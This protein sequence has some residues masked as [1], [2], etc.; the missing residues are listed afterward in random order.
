[1][2][3]S[4][5]LP[6]T[7][8]LFHC[9]RILLILALALCTAAPLRAA[10]VTERFGEHATADVT[11]V[12]SD[13]TVDPNSPGNVDPLGETLYYR[14][15]RSMIMRFDL[16]AI[17]SGTRIRRAVVRFFY[18]REDG[19]FTL[20][21]YEGGKD[22]TIMPLRILFDPQ[23]S[24]GWVPGEASFLNKRA[25][26]PWNVGGNFEGALGVEIGSVYFR[27]WYARGQDWHDARITEAVQYWV[28]N[29]ERN[30]G[31]GIG[32]A[33]MFNKRICS[34]R[35]SDAMRRPY[36][37]V[38]YE[39]D[40]AQAPPQS[41]EVEAV[42]TDGQ[43]FVTWNEATT[44][45]DETS[46]RIYRHDEPIT[47]GNLDE[48]E[49]LDE[50]YQGS[51][52]ISDAAKIG[53][54]D[55]SPIGV[56]LEPRAGLFVY[57]VENAQTS[58]YAVTTVVE[59]NEN[60]II[61]AGNT[62][63]AGVS[64]AIGLPRPFYFNH[65]G[66]DRYYI[67]LVMFLGSFNPEN[68]ADEFGFD[69]RRSA[70]FFFSVAE[71]F[72][73]DRDLRYP[74]NLFLHAS[75]KSYFGSGEG[76]D[77]TRVVDGE[78]FGGFALGINDQPRVV[79]RNAAGDLLDLGP[80][81]ETT[82][83]GYTYYAGFNSNYTPGHIKQGFRKSL[84]ISQPFSQ[85]RNVL[86]TEKSIM[87]VMDWLQER[88]P[89]SQNIDSD[90]V[91]ANGYSMG[92]AGVL[93]LALHYPNRIAVADAVVGRTAIV[94]Q[95][96]Y[97]YHAPVH[98]GTTEMGVPTPEGD[99]LFAKMRL[100]QYIKT[101]PWVEFPPIR[102]TN[103]RNDFV[104][105]W[106]PAP[107]FWKA[108]LSERM[109]IISLW[110]TSEHNGNWA[111]AQPDYV[112]PRDMVAEMH[113]D[114]FNLFRYSLRESYPAFGD[115]SLDDDP[116]NGPR[117][118]GD[119]T[120]GI[121]RYP[122]WER[123][124]L[125]DELNRYEVTVFMLDSAPEETATVTVIPRRIQFLLHEPG[126]VYD[127]RNE[128]LDGGGTLQS[129]VV[130][131][132]GYH[133]VVVEGFE[134]G[135]QATRLVLE[136][137]TGADQTPPSAP[138]VLTA[139]Q[140]T[141][142][143]IVLNWSAANDDT[144]VAGYVVYN[145]EGEAVRRVEGTGATIANLLN[146]VSYTFHVRAYDAAGNLSVPSAPASAQ[147]HA[148]GVN[149]PPFIDMA[150][151]I[152]V[153]RGRKLELPI[154]AGDP[155]SYLPRVSV[156]G[157]PTGASYDA[158]TRIVTWLPKFDQAGDHTIS[159]TVE[160]EI[161][162]TTKNVRL[163]VSQE[164]DPARLGKVETYGAFISGGVQIEV[165]GSDGNEWARLYVARAEEAGPMREAHPFVRY[166]LNHMATSLF[167]LEAGTAYRVRVVMTDPDGGVTTTETLLTTRPEWT[168][169]APVREV[170]IND[171]EELRAAI[172][173]V[174]PGDHLVLAPGS[175][176]GDFELRDKPGQADR[177]IVLR[178]RDLNHK[179]VLVGTVGNTRSPYVTYCGLEVIEGGIAARGAN[180]LEIV[181]CVISD[182]GGNYESALIHISH[183][184]EVPG[185]DKAGHN[186]I[187]NNLLT[188]E[189]STGPS[190]RTYF[191]IRRH[192]GVRGFDIIRGNIIRGVDDGISPGG[193]EGQSP[194]LGP[195]AT[196]VLKSWPNQN[197]DIYDNVIYDMADDCIETDG[198]MVNCRI[199]NNIL[200]ASI[201]AVSTA[202]TW[203]GP[204]FIVRNRMHGF[205]ENS[206][207]LNTGVAGETRNVFMYH[208]T[209]KQH[210][211]S[212]YC[213]YRGLP[214]RNRNIIWR[215]NIIEST[216]RII[217]TDISSDT[218][219]DNHHTNHSFDHDLLWTP[220][221]PGGET[222]LFKWGY[223]T[224]GDNE[225]Y[226]SL[227][228]FQAATANP[229][230]TFQCADQR[231]IPQEPNGI[232]G[233]PLLAEDVPANYGA[234][235]LLL[236]LVPGTGSPAIDA[237]VAIP[238][239][240]DWFEGAG[241]DI[242]AIEVGRDSGAAPRLVAD[243]PTNLFVSLLDSGNP[244]TVTIEG[245]WE[246]YSATDR[247]GGSDYFLN[248]SEAGAGGSITFHP[249]IEQEGGYDVY[250]YYVHHPN[251][252]TRVPVTIEHARGVD[253][254]TINQREPGGRFR[255]I[256]QYWFAPGR[257]AA[258][259]FST[260][261]VD[262]GYVIVD[263]V[264]LI[265][266]VDPRKEAVEG[267]AY[268]SQSAMVTPPVQ[269]DY[270]DT[271]SA[272]VGA[273]ISVWGVSFGEERNGGSVLIGDVAA[274]EY[275]RWS[276]ERIDFR[277]PEGAASGPLWVYASRGH[278][279][280]L[281]FAVRPGDLHLVD[282]GH[283][284][285]SDSG[286][287][288]MEQPWAT[289]A[290]AAAAAEAGDTIYIAQGIYNETLEP[291]GTGTEGLPIVFKGLPGALPLL[292][293]GGLPDTPDGIR[294][295][296]SGL[297]QL[298]GHMVFTDLLLRNFDQSVHIGLG[299][300][301]IGL[302]GLDVGYG[303]GGL[304][305][306]GSSD[307]FVAHCR[308]HNNQDFG[309]VFNNFASDIEIRDSA[310]HDNAALEGGGFEADDTVS[311][312]TLHRCVAYDNPG[313]GYDLRVDALVVNESVGF[314]N[315]IGLRLWRNAR[316]QNSQFNDNA[317]CGIVCERVGADQ[318]MQQ[319][320]NC[321]VAGGHAVAGIDV[322]ELVD[323]RVINTIAV[324]SDGPAM[325]FEGLPAGDALENLI[326]HSTGEETL[327]L[328]AAQA[329]P[330]NLN[331]LDIEAGLLTDLIGVSA[332]MRVETNPTSLFLDMERGDLRLAE[333]SAARGF[334]L[335]DKAPGHDLVRNVRHDYGASV[336]AGAFEFP[337]GPASAGAAWAQYR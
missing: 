98:W 162:Q 286:P 237:A 305:M 32:T 166:D 279:Q 56:Y 134:I 3:S 229:D 24:G 182:A 131:A 144:G 123:E 106:R 71:P 133:R 218:P 129:G 59:G 278:T 327:L 147:T 186:L 208:N 72:H 117:E 336:D 35:S 258:I 64:E 92:S 265:L 43:T 312:V 178:S 13:Q 125:V 99:D 85:G 167:D 188:D 77:N 185:A 281:G 82:D 91:M 255:A 103:N 179:A 332:P 170:A 274:T 115:F 187:M 239:I 263:A 287:G 163:R 296:G 6:R 90:R 256:G 112:N 319:I 151:V 60:R 19:T 310:S 251:R 130:T 250:V 38:T 214:S 219:C 293:G 331:A 79:V 304:Y 10:W 232:F 83:F 200:G 198:H 137:R 168:L 193:V 52:W 268:R 211:S 192:W 50:V 28:N 5:V 18:A 253:Q 119:G 146:G 31:F 241:P 223:S 41:G 148:G 298:R 249:E 212:N 39:T 95:G 78:R 113:G 180:H 228:A 306:F 138:A 97:S 145:S 238:G 17:P 240:N 159:V 314:N 155:D 108:A 55:L 221:T 207:K 156:E 236:T 205:R 105:D 325:R 36:L 70:P 246:T 67:G 69:N 275:A 44:G 322:K 290:H 328:G 58:H 315:G 260:A 259:T 183:D 316:V 54:P 227:E 154:I 333:R 248:P 303:Q 173:D 282:P 271:L 86:Y 121:N 181:E 80:Y 42:H 93:A 272:P 15:P 122:T 300:H 150:E 184:E 107:A 201:N 177:R 254:V 307:L 234:E 53:Q 291:V 213:V 165:E 230:Q 257:P 110:G 175:Y 37:E 321:T 210:E 136:R 203:P 289:L 11:G 29:P 120:G 153:R 317:D 329:L 40:N 124:T 141:Q 172:A 135:K 62:T 57:T 16:S 243:T 262:D 233:D 126:T 140:G 75:T 311:S 158:A 337:K 247:I 8:R 334:G 23:G 220:V 46:Y 14:S 225:R 191:G 26:V 88:S 224:W 277:V 128:A 74:L 4:R 276:D 301:H 81:H 152:E 132:D 45:V 292:T 51:S 7:A 235:T 111:N 65:Q 215:N 174:R 142:G 335:A 299:A 330:I 284:L 116:G 318:P 195:D 149:Q 261:G 76:R 326:V 294:V 295:M 266:A 244:E 197:Q 21:Y 139:R 164:A 242:G 217:D 313:A 30:L 190:D 94:E 280:A 34:S 171:A 114:R 176:V 288:T 320:V 87:F 89:W 143:R 270:A 68:P 194:L 161:Q 204:I 196:D 96:M 264:K 66:P 104:I 206:L 12:T 102:A 47:G 2:E 226:A 33:G 199:F 25:G 84:K 20:D 297:P 283:P 245:P 157:L 267:P 269:L 202:P 127:W 252:A 100:A 160:D 222:P 189:R 209:I 323:A 309:V 302:F 231:V 27:S 9:P 273:W 73:Y 216:R 324:G 1:M 101:Y 285:A 61:E 308:F 109:G 63:A 22:E 118:E 169:Q 48:A 49:L